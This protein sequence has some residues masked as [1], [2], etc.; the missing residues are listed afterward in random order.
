MG[1]EWII[2]NSGDSFHWR[3]YEVGPWHNEAEWDKFKR[4]GEL[5]YMAEKERQAFDFISGHPVWFAR[6]TVRRIVYLWTGYW[7]LEPATWN[8]GRSIR[9][10]FSSAAR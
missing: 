5:N 1:L 9:R 7:S 10:T 2:G 6:Q 8:K 4:I 3:P